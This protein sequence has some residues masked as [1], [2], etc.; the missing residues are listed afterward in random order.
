MPWPKSLTLPEPYDARIRAQHPN[1][2]SSTMTNAT[3][4]SSHDDASPSDLLTE[5]KPGMT[6]TINRTETILDPRNRSVNQLGLFL[7]GCALTTFSVLLT[8]RSVSRRINALR[9]KGTFTPSTTT[10]ALKV[11]GGAEAA[12]ALGLATLNVGSVAFM[13]G[14]GALW[15]FDISSREELRIKLRRRMSLDA[16]EMVGKGEES[17]DGQEEQKEDL[18][19]WFEVM[20]ARLQ[21]KSEAE[22]AAL[23]L[24]KEEEMK[25]KAQ[26]QADMEQQ[27]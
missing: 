26:T 13:L 5:I 6:S 9:P 8:R 21:G 20:S 12:E 18:E 25:A 2:S 3:T 10:D 14:A 27:A 23:V 17:E 16:A 24:Q 11:N 19:I 15:A 22:I 1:S 7:A 4:A